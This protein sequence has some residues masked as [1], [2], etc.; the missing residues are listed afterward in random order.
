MHRY[1]TLV[2]FKK[3]KK[4]LFDFVSIFWINLTVSMENAGRA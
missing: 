4:I 3:K 1:I 2:I